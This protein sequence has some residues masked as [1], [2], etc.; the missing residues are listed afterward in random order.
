MPRRRPE[1][2]EVPLRRRIARAVGRRELKNCSSSAGDAARQ[3][4]GARVRADQHVDFL[5]FLRSAIDIP[6]GS[7]PAGAKDVLAAITE[8]PAVHSRRAVR[9]ILSRSS[10]GLALLA[11][12]PSPRSILQPR[13]PART[14]ARVEDLRRGSGNTRYSP[15]DQPTRPT[16]KLKIAWRLTTNESG[17]D[18][19]LYSATPLFVGNVLY[20]TSGRLGRSSRSTTTGGAV[21]T[22]KTKGRGQNAPQRR[23]AV[24]RVV[25]PNGSDQRI[26]YVTPGYR[27]LALD[28]DRRADFDIRTTASST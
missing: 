21:S 13:T 5:A 23:G 20:T 9:R 10:A 12:R 17:R 18:R 27:M 2:R 16:S 8:T 19:T 6:G 22:S 1:G 15:L 14:A 11:W 26:I 7:Q 28:A 4:S 25:R 3:S 24:S